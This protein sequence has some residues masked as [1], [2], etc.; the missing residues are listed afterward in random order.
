MGH[1]GDSV[2]ACL[3]DFGST[4]TKVM[5]VDIEKAK[6]VARAKAVSTVEKNVMIGLE[7][8]LSELKISRESLSEKFCYKLACSSAAGGL[9]MIAIG[10]VPELTAKAARRAALGAGARVLNTFSHKL[11]P[12]EIEQIENQSPDIILLA[13]GTD[14]GEKKTIIFNA[15][16]LAESRIQVP[17]VIAGNKEASGEVESILKEKG[18]DVRVTE[19]VLPMLGELNIEPAKEVIR[20]IFMERIVEAK[21]LGETREFVDILM[22]TPAAT[23]KAAELLANG[24]K[25]ETGLGEILVV[26]VG[27]ATTNVYS[28]AEGMPTQTRTILKGLKEPHSKRTVEGDLGVRVSAESLLA[29]AG[30]ERII[31]NLEAELNG[32]VDFDIENFVR[33]LSHNIGVIPHLKDEYAIDT[34]LAQVAVETAIERHVGSIEGFFSPCLLY[35]SDAADE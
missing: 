23:L 3:I 29:V 31:K 9:R 21:G 18:K 12:S 17:I 5:I 13:G 35:T 33:N 30:K 26:E 25:E 34:A 16:A 1:N 14:G 20:N 10:L 28:I 6:V 2:E 4:F 7:K 19:N 24:T 22:P 27:G 8:A 11:T 32:S 15:N